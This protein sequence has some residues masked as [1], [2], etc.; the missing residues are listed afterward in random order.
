M[1]LRLYGTSLGPSEAE[2]HETDRSK[3]KFSKLSRMLGTTPLDGNNI[4]WGPL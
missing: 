3:V 2:R 4:I 1:P